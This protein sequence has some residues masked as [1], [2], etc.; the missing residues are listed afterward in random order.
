[1]A[2]RTADIHIRIQPD[3]KKQAE[4][5]FAEGGF[6]LTDGIEQFLDW[7]VRHKKSPIRLQ[8]RRPNIPV[9]SEMSKEEIKAELAKSEED[10]K[11]GNIYNQEQVELMVRERYGF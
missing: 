8:K 6:T 5:I 10:F 2:T 7:T 3:L 9:L 4:R 11:K 1:M